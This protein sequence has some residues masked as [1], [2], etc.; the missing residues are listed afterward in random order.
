MGAPGL[1]G[2][3]HSVLEQHGG[4]AAGAADGHFDPLPVIRSLP[5]AIAIGWPRLMTWPSAIV[6]S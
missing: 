4:R 2:D 6:P 3:L 5:P 1:Y